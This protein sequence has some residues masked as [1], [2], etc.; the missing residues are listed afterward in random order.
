MQRTWKLLLVAMVGVWLLAA[1]S[2][3]VGIA[4]TVAETISQDEVVVEQV[5]VAEPATAVSVQPIAVEPTAIEMIEAEPEAEVVEE[6]A[7]QSTTVE[8]QKAEPI[9]RPPGQ[10]VDEYVNVSY[11]QADAELVGKTNR[12][13][14][15]NVYAN[16]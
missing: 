8:Q 9:E 1:C 12:V 4:E 7:V 10:T 14:F 2:G 3:E 16:W 15:I 13:Q 6:T 5:V 11:T